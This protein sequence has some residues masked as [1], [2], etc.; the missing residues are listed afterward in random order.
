[1]IDLLAL[2]ELSDLMREGPEVWSHRCVTCSKKA[3]TTTRSSP[4]DEQLTESAHPPF[5]APTPRRS[6]P[7]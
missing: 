7:P 4:A 2:A 3:E 5:V 6:P 1:M